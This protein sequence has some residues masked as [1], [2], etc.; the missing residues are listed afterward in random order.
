MSALVRFSLLISIIFINPCV[1]MYKYYTD[2][3]SAL[4]NFSHSKL[5]A[6]CNEKCM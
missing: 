4:S 6:S 2:L 1:N 5:C 3:K